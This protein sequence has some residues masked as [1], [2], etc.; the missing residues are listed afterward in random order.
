MIILPIRPCGTSRVLLHAVKYY[1]MGP[2]LP[3]GR[4]AAD[5]YPLPWPGFE[6]ATFGSSGQHTNHYIT[7]I[8]SLHLKEK[9]AEN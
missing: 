4:C 3:R 5:F 7:K 9:I 1:D 8:T 2:S 6:P